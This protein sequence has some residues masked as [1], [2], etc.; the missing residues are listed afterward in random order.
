MDAP[1]RAAEQLARFGLVKIGCSA[2][3]QRERGHPHPGA[4][5]QRRIPEPQRCHHRDLRGRQLDCKGVLLEYLLVAPATGA[6]KLDHHRRRVR[7][8][9]PVDA[10][11]VAVEREHMPVRR[12][13]GCLGRTEHRV[14]CQ[15][16]E[17]PRVISGAHATAL[18]VPD[19]TAGAAA[20]I[21]GNSSAT[22]LQES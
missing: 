15:R 16:G 17:R 1:E 10:V 2:R 6:V 12:Q 13:P 18:A 8:A 9:E 5:V 14:G 19:T 20:G 11:F 22:G 21:M 7:A 3:L 4:V